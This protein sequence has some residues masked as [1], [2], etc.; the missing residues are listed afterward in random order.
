M[1]KRPWMANL[2][3]EELNIAKVQSTELEWLFLVKIRFIFAF[4]RLCL[5]AFTNVPDSNVQPF[6]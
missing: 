6:H 3:I 5:V 4:S 2:Q 1:N